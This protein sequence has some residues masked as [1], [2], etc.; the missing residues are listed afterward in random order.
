MGAIQDSLNSMITTAALGAAGAK[1]LAEQSQANMIKGAEL[2]SDVIEK[3]A[4]IK[5]LGESQAAIA[6]EH[7]ELGTPMEESALRAEEAAG[8]DDL[9]KAKEA[10]ASLS[11]KIA[12]KT[13]QKAALERTMANIGKT[14]M[15]IL[16]ER[17]A[18]KMKSA[19]SRLFGGKR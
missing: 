3:E 18:S 19:A 12:A 14:P 17:G 15:Q 2:K 7:P 4:E 5:E 11:N 9:A 13:A 10:M 1:H 16:A 6:A 8:G